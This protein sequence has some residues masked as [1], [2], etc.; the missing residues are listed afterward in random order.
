MPDRPLD[1]QE[2]VMRYLRARFPRASLALFIITPISGKDFN[3]PEAVV[4]MELLQNFCCHD[5]LTLAVATCLQETR[6]IPPTSHQV[7]PYD[8]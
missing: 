3:D 8:A 5:H 7:R 6:D 1:E 4:D 2:A